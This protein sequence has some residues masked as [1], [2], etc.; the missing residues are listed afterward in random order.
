MRKSDDTLHFYLNGCELDNRF[1]QVDKKLYAVVDIYGG[2]EEVTITG[3]SIGMITGHRFF[4]I[5]QEQNRIYDRG[6]TN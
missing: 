2:A 3:S 6:D 4:F 1:G 5:I